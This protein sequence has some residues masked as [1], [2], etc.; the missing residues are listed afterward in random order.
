M[1]CPFADIANLYGTGPIQ[2]SRNLLSYT[3]RRPIGEAARE[4][5]APTIQGEVDMDI[6]ANLQPDE[7][8]QDESFDDFDDRGGVLSDYLEDDEFNELG[9]LYRYCVCPRWGARR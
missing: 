2:N 6:N 9:F 3:N 7:M 8:F 1:K 5:S 4:S